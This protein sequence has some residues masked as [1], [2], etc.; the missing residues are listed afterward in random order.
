MVN[1]FQTY[2][3]QTGT[4]LHPTA[5]NFEFFLADATGTGQLDLFVIKKNQTGSGSTEVSV[6]SAESGY[7]SFLLQTGTPQHET[8]DKFA[9]AV[10]D[11]AGTGS[12]DL[13]VI[14]KNQTGSGSTEVSVLS[15]ESGYQ[16]F[17]L[18]TGTPQHETD[19]R[20]AFTLA[21][22]RLAKHCDLAVIK[23]SDT[24]T[25]KTEIGILR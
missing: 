15:A 5:D 3:L 8:D 21:Y 17:L 12:A 13:F 14:K 24:G 19:R 22:N 4:A 25:G 20:F 16:N 18:Q 6:L 23:K 2:V 1:S 9:F 11:F 10:A 7:Q